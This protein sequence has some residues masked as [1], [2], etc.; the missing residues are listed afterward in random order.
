VWDRGGALGV[1]VRYGGAWAAP[2]ERGPA[3][4]EGKGVGPGRKDDGP[5]QR[6]SA[7][8]QLIDFF[9]TD[10]NLNWSK[11]CLPLLEQFQIK[12]GFVGN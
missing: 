2:R 11:G 8:S 5:C 6:N 7:V 12:Y 9:K 3:R 4:E 10:S 1:G